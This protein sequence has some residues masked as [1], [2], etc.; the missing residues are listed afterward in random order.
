MKIHSSPW[1]SPSTNVNGWG[2]P[3]AKAQISSDSIDA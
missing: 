2:L 3:M 1:V